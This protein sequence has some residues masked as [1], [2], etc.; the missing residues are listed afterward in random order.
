MG[1]T[2]SNESWSNAA[3]PT[4]S[5]TNLQ[6]STERVNGIVDFSLI[7]PDPSLWSVSVMMMER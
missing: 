6:Y 7:F 5:H 2:I 3:A 4:V 1:L